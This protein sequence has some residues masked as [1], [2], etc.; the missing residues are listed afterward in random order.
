MPRL[1]YKTDA[2]AGP[3]EI[4]SAI[5]E[6]RG[7]TLL[8]LDR[9]LLYSPPLALGWNALMGAVRTRLEL[10]AG[11]REI[12]ICVVATINRAPYEFHHHAPVLVAAGGSEA[13]VEAL[14]DVDVAATRTDLF[15]RGELAALRLAVE[16]TRTVRVGDAVFEEARAALADDSILV[17]LV[18]TIAAYNMVSRVM[19]ALGIEPEAASAKP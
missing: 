8:N 4:V 10:P 15:D 11:L 16:M 7:G 1:P 14:R 3:E 9:Q 13:Q 6:R 2:A 19:V 17:E 12:A 18:A 5:R